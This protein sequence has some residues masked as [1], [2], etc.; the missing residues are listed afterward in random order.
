MS[1][2]AHPAVRH[3]NPIPGPNALPASLLV[4]RG[5]LCR[6]LSGFPRFGS[7]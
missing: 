6:I 7:T 3:L 5:K 1:K 4:R 2:D